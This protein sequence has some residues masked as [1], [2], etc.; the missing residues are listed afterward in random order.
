MNSI[1]AEIYFHS[2]LMCMGFN[3]VITTQWMRY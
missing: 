2:L 3:S 1:I